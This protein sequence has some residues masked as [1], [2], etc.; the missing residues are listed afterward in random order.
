MSDAAAIITAL[1]GLGGI[2]TV[3]ASVATLVQARRI[4]ADTETLSPN[5]GSSLADSVRRI[6][7]E[8]TKAAA[9]VLIL[10]HKVDGLARE[11]KIVGYE[12]GDLRTTRDREHADYDA[13]IRALESPDK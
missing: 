9:D 8:Q 2:G 7:A 12:V 13:R 1:G 3:V 4:K 10:S 6:E 5:H 11:V